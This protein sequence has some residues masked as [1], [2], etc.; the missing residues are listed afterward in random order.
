MTRPKKKVSSLIT[1][2][3]GKI[4]RKWALELDLHGFKSWPLTFGI[5]IGLDQVI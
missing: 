5:R 3:D 4:E 2:Q 1:E